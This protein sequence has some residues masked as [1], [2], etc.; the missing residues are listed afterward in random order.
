MYVLLF[1]ACLYFVSEPVAELFHCLIFDLRVIWELFYAELS[2]LCFNMC[3]RFSVRTL[4][5]FFSL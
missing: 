4:S 2:N 5:G 1:L 3:L